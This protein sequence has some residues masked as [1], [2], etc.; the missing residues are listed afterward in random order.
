MGGFLEIQ[1]DRNISSDLI[2]EIADFVIKNGQGLYTRLDW[3]VI[4]EFAKKHID[5]KTIIIVRDEQGILAVCRWNIINIETA[6]IMD[7]I[8]RKGHT[9]KQMI[10]RIL[11]KGIRIFPEAKWL[12]FKREKKYPN[13]NKRKYLISDIL[14]RRK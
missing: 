1:H 12:E 2:D 6:F 13:R 3:D 14:K 7:L 8:I 4:K 5:Y 10:K 9:Y 11:L